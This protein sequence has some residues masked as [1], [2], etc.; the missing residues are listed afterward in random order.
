L[1]FVSGKKILDDNPFFD[2]S[3]IDMKYPKYILPFLVLLSTAILLNSCSQDS[4]P[5]SLEDGAITS[6]PILRGERGDQMVT[7]SWNWLEL[8]FQELRENYARPE[9]FEILISESDPDQWSILDQV[10]IDQSVYEVA[11]LEND[12]IYY[13]SILAI[14]ES[15][16]SSPSNTIMIMPG[17]AEQVN[18]VFSDHDKNRFW[19]S[20]SPDGKSI[21]YQVDPAFNSFPVNDT[22]SGIFTYNLE[23]QQEQFITQ[24]NMPDWS[25]HTQQF[26][27]H[28]QLDSDQNQL[29]IYDLTQ[30]TIV[31]LNAPS[32]LNQQ[33]SWSNQ[34]NS[35]IFLSNFPD[36]N[37]YQVYEIFMQAGLFQAA[38][39]FYLSPFSNQDPGSIDWLSPMTP[40]WLP[41]DEGIIF[42]EVNET[43]NQ[44]RRQIYT[45]IPGEN[46]RQAFFDSGWNDQ[47]P[48][49]SPG[50]EY[51]AFI[52]DR[53]G[54]KSIW[55]YHLPTENFRQL[56]ANVP[57]GHGNN[58]IGDK[59]S[60]APD[61]TK[62]LF[63]AP[64]A[65]TNHLTLFTVNVF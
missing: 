9:R 29:F 55:L 20:Y 48:V 18:P 17:A 14:S 26:A 22:L 12:Q 30:E 49:F 64:S 15:G 42:S 39:Q 13:F 41:N 23:N 32:G 2:N 53:T 59:L 11:G 43:Y 5:N 3:E 33:A 7:L 65:S 47:S 24:G 62:I 60:W 52:S 21:V 31:E 8:D 6:P 37:L 58:R 16:Q 25:P 46:S 38:N 10:N 63:T 4:T 19:G 51:L 27:F 40:Q 35:L 61:G 50:G 56:T 54:R 45:F 57:V 1:I 44:A 36:K 28:R 34:G